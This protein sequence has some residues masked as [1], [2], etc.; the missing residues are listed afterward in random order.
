LGGGAYARSEILEGK[1]LDN[2]ILARPYLSRSG[3]V[4][5][6]ETQGY[7]KSRIKSALDSDNADGVIGSMLQ[8]GTIRAHEHGWVVVD[9]SLASVLML[10]RGAKNEAN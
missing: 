7:T 10:C 3:L 1:N 5:Y 9:E 4:A 8:A 6:L 2:E